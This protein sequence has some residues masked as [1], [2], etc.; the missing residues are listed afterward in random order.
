MLKLRDGARQDVPVIM[1]AATLGRGI[2]ELRTAVAQC[3][4]RTPEEKVRLRARRIRRLIA[5]AAAGLARRLVIDHSGNLV[6]TLG[7]SASTGEIS[8][9]EAAMELLR[10]INLDSHKTRDLV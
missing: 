5:Q 6:D 9:E 8:F 4:Q 10:K 2:E 3:L 7:Q 1:T